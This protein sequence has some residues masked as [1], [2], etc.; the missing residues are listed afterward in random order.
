MKTAQNRHRLAKLVFFLVVLA[1]A[2]VAG[3]ILFYYQSDDDEHLASKEAYLKRIA[4]LSEKPAGPN[5]VLILFDDL[6]YGDLAAYGSRAIRTPNLDRLAREGLRFTNAYSASPCSAS[7]AGLLTGRYAVR[8]GLDHV[9][10]PPEEPYDKLLRLGGRHR[11]L[12]TPGST[13][14]S[15]RS[16][17]GASARSWRPWTA[18]A[19]PRR[20]PPGSGAF[21]PW[22]EIPCPPFL[23]GSASTSVER[24]EGPPLGAQASCL[25]WEGAAFPSAEDSTPAVRA[26]R[27]LSPLGP[28]PVKPKARASDTTAR[29]RASPAQG[30]ATSQTAPLPSEQT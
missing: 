13:A 27:G 21:S 1:A 17:T 18:P 22:V 4:G 12:P 23:K 20:S 2:L 19:S 5:V 24:P 6:G 25:L 30:P 28:S 9:L 10:Q 29:R 7:R 11:R 16:S 8:S 26:C 14:T 3:R 15:S